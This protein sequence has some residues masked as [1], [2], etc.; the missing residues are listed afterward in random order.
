MTCVSFKNCIQQ[1]PRWP[2]WSVHASTGAS[3]TCAKRVTE[4]LSGGESL[5]L[6]FMRDFYESISIKRTADMMAS[7]I[8]DFVQTEGR[9]S[10][11]SS[12]KT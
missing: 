12:S 10:L 7:E 8:G 11:F 2:A 5:P 6:V 1:E 4:P 9:E 3:R